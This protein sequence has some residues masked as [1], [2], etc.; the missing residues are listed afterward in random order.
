MLMGNES[1]QHFASWLSSLPVLMGN[2]ST[3]QFASWLASSA[4][5]LALLF[6]SLLLIAVILALVT[7]KKKKGSKRKLAS[8][9]TY[10]ACFGGEENIV[11]KKLVGSRIAIT[12]KDASIVD[13]EKLKEA[14][15]DAFILMSNRL[16]LVTKGEAKDL[17]F[18]LFGEKA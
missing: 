3:Q 2:E 18:I 8:K 15:V 5:W 7:G 16:T 1:T 17:Y 9:D 13:Q 12:L 4:W 11:D 14:G 6:A 10:L